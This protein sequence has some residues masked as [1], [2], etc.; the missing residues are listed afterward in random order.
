MP[1]LEKS[2]EKLEI[3][4]EGF[5]LDDCLAESDETSSKTRSKT[6]RSKTFNFKGQTSHDLN[7]DVM[8]DPDYPADAVN[9]NIIVEEIE[10]NGRI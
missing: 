4:L 8:E 9:S 10:M 6:M 7:F 5:S 2:K 1:K 3:P